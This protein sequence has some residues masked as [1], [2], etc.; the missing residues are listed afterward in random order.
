VPIVSAHFRSLLILTQFLFAGTD[1]EYDVFSVSVL[2]C[3]LYSVVMVKLNHIFNSGMHLQ[4][5]TKTTAVR[6]YLLL[7]ASLEHSRPKL[8]MK[9]HMANKPAAICYTSLLA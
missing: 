5:N 2:V 9:Y 1:A 6:V 4:I 3:H 7:S 8:A